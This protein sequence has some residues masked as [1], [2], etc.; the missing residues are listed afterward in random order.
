MILQVEP[1]VDD[2]ELEQVTE[3]IRSTWLTEAEKTAQFEREFAAR[4]GARHAITVSNATGGLFVAL[5]AFDIGPGDEVIVPAMTFVA[6]VNAV[7]MAG[8]TPVLVDVDP[9]DLNLALADVERAIS[10]RT[11]ALMPVHLYGRSFDLDG[12]RGVAD[13]HGLRMIEDAAQAVG[14]VHRGRHVGTTGD[15]ACFSFFGNKTMTSG[16]GGMLTTQDD[17]VAQRCRILK[18]HGRTTRGTFVHDHIGFNFG[19]TEL[20]AAVGLA[21]LRKLERILARKRAIERRYQDAL[22]GLSGLRFPP[23]DVTGVPVPWF[24]S[25]FVADPARLAQALAAREIQTRRLFPPIHR[26]PCYRGRF[27]DDYPHADRAYDTGLSLPS[28]VTLTDE[29]VDTV[30]QAIREALAEAPGDGR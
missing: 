29:Q 11:R 21:Q 30:C 14:T 8:A 3:V 19:F 1:W 13:R 10:P 22:A 9:D 6:T 24:T 2:E 27:T 12:A 23:P 16:Q 7:I 20:Q 17:E 26:Q 28:G 25:V 18:N 4:V 5:K 15:V